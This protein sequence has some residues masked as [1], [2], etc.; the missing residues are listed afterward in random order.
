MNIDLS[1][2][3]WTDEQFNAYLADVRSWY[4]TGRE[5]DLEEAVEYHRTMPAERNMV[6]AQVKAA[7]EGNVLV[8]ARAGFATIDQTLETH[9]YT[10][11]HG[12]SDIVRVS[13]DTYTR[14]MQFDRAKQA[15]EESHRQGRSLLNGFPSVVHGV[16]GN[17]RLYEGIRLPV[18]STCAAAHT[19]LHS[20]I[21]LAA[22]AT[23]AMADAFQG[24][25]HESR[26]RLGDIIKYRQFVDRLVGWYEERGI[27]ISK[28]NKF[29]GVLTPPCIRIAS[30]ILGML[31]GAAQGVKNFSLEYNT[32]LSVVQ[33]VAAQRVLGA[34]S[35]EYLKRFGYQGRIM[36]A[37]SL[38]NG[39]HPPDRSRAFSL[40]L[41]GTAIAKWG[42]ANRLDGRTVDE[43][44]GLPTKDGQAM[45]L[46]AMKEMLYLLR[47]QKFPESE[48]LAS[49]QAVI[50]CETRAI[51]ERVLELGEGDVAVGAVKALE[52]GT[53]DY[54]YPVNK[55][56]PGKVTSVRDKTGAVRLLDC[57]NLPF[58][59]EMIEFHRQRIA[60]RRQAENR[61][62]YQM[63]I[64]DLT[65]KALVVA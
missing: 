46:R 7:A 38:Y 60:E 58:S 20:L 22:G 59:R 25:F 56:I 17:R 24:L 30:T 57:G 34:M 9:A 10:R 48:E 11:D 41:L 49:E 26:V 52:L 8:C 37:V 36:Q 1:N 27:E 29:V 62:D 54:T 45:S 2:K 19:E 64:E 63:I 47:N 5:V 18:G 23:E 42:G 65:N 35:R 12:G 16:A 55:T 4:E 13:V 28:E 21:T 33:D 14:R 61:K 53:L 15:L 31:L 40:I 50:E 44:V 32:N 3:K 6:K 39:A 43:G 51:L